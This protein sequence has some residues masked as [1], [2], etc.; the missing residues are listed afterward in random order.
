MIELK[1]AFRSDSL[2]FIQEDPTAK[3]DESEYTT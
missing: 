1:E 2:T 3:M